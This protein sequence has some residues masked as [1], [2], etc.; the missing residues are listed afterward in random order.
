MNYHPVLLALLPALFL[1]QFSSYF[2]SGIGMAAYGRQ[3]LAM[4]M[5]S[6]VGALTGVLIAFVAF[7]P[8]IALALGLSFLSTII[9]SLKPTATLDTFGLFLGLTLTY[10]PSA[11]DVITQLGSQLII[12]AV[13]GGYYL[14][15]INTARHAHH[16]LAEQH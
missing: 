3:R 11:I 12:L 5:E 7:D 4:F 10:W 2:T 14:L 9:S 1:Y 16:M 6:I 13:A 8:I 15:Q